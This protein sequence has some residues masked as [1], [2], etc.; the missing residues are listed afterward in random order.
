MLVGHVLW[1]T[2]NSWR[3]THVD[4]LHAQ[5]P[6]LKAAYYGGRRVTSRT[7]SREWD[8]EGQSRVQ[9]G[10]GGCAIGRTR[11]L[12]RISA[13]TDRLYLCTACRANRPITAPWI[14]LLACH[15]WPCLP[16]KRLSRHTPLMQPSNVWKARARDAAL[17]VVYYRAARDPSPVVY[18]APFPRPS[19]PSFRP[20]FNPGTTSSCSILP[21][22]N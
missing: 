1:A 10:T 11:R 13:H 6:L 18:L 4:V 2:V 16:P 20:H 3:A 5:E 17:D 8:L 21:R 22:R 12:R 7:R 14:L 9:R 15:Y 19:L